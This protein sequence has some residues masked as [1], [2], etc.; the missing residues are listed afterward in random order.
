[1]ERGQFFF[2]FYF[3]PVKGGKGKKKE[4]RGVGI[5]LFVARRGEQIAQQ[6]EAPFSSTRKERK[7]KLESFSSPFYLGRKKT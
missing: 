7:K 4:K 3:W 6:G 2:T 5:L 1:M